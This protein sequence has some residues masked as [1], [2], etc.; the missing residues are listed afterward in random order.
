MGKEKA[1]T[2]FLVTSSKEERGHRFA[3]DVTVVLRLDVTRVACLPRQRDLYLF[4]RQNL[5]MIT[6]FCPRI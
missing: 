5:Q 6:V 1:S 3:L 2:A 4:L